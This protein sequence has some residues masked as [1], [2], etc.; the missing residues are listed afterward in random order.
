MGNDYYTS[1][2]EFLVTTLGG[3]YIA[4]VM[5][6]FLFQLVRAD[7]YNPISQFL[8][9]IT[10]PLLVPLR[11]VIP[12]FGG[13]DVASIVLMLLLQMLVFAL[14]VVLRG[15]TPTPLFL[16]GLAV[17]E[18]LQV[19]VNI[20]FWAI[21]LQAILS[22]VQPG[23]HNPGTMLLHQLTAP[24]LNPARRLLPPISGLDLSPILVVIGLKLLEMI[25]LPPLQR[26]LM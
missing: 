21:I 10:S 12:G 3:L 20:F 22:W 19:A 18:L 23:Q 14:V 16:L 13:I 25:L 11:R 2:V 5:L 9:K 8:V 4:A 15:A 6:R 17:V 26:L 1:P 7:F 24:L